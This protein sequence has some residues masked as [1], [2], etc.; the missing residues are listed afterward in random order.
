MPEPIVERKDVETALEARQELGPDY[1]RQVI[2]AFVDRIERRVDDRL[3]EM[4]PK[5]PRPIP[6]LLP[7]GS[8]GIGIGMTGAALG[9]T[10]GGAGGVLV[11]I[12]AWIAI[13]VVNLAY[14]ATRR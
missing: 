1:E 2:D 10:N 11:A 7:L 9:P 14:A 4:K 13:A 3:A 6:L 5:G 12:V 8:M